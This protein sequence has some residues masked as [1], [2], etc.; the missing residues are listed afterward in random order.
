MDSYAGVSGNVLITE[1]ATRLCSYLVW[2]YAEGHDS[3]YRS[4]LVDLTQPT[5]KACYLLFSIV[6]QTLLLVAYVLM[7]RMLKYYINAQSSNQCFNDQ[8]DR[9]QLSTVK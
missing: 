9:T 4:M 3:Y 6:C 1:K 8:F 5:G 7:T 2:D